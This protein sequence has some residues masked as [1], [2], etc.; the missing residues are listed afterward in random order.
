MRR[1]IIFHRNSKMKKY[2]M[3]STMFCGRMEPKKKNMTV[4]T[5]TALQAECAR[6]FHSRLSSILFAKNRNDKKHFHNTAKKKNQETEREREKTTFKLY[7]N[8]NENHDRA[9]ENAKIEKKT[10]I[11]FIFIHLK[12]DLLKAPA[13][14]SDSKRFREFFWKKIVKFDEFKERAPFNTLFFLCIVM[15]AYHFYV[16]WWK[17]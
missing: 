3:K 11:L 13:K 12:W 10:I 9:Q 15:F 7:L 1:N 17:L 5:P 4:R 16:N 2:K 6:F 14:K 8:W